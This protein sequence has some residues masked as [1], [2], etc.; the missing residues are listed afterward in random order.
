MYDYST[1]YINAIP[2]K[3]RKSNELVSAFKICYDE[4]KQKGF[5]ARVLRLDNEISAELIKAIE[6]EHLDYQ[7][8]LPGDHRLNHAGRAVQTF[9]SKFISFR[10]GADPS[11]PKNC[12][13]LFI[14]QTVLAMNLMR[15]AYTQVHGEFD[16]S[17]T[18]IA[19]IGCKVIVH[20]RRGE[21]GSWDNHGSHGYY[22]ESTS[23]LPELHML[24]A[25]H[26]EESYIKYCQVF[27]RTVCATASHTHRLINRIPVMPV[28]LRPLLG[29]ILLRG[30]ISLK[31][32]SYCPLLRVSTSPF[33][34]KCLFIYLNEVPVA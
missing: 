34:S 6:E 19:P 26:K 3:S 24:H 28:I 27:P 22:I 31:N 13:D 30:C 12:W 16:F 33:K 20:D 15:P 21:R 17:R 32:W 11:F 14:A 5:T 18:P 8:V 2:I 1:N 4:L 7:I 29:V 9:K 23:S 25:R 10:E